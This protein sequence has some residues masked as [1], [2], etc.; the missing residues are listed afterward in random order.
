MRK[1]IVIEW[2]QSFDPKDSTCSKCFHAP[3]EEIEG[4]TTIRTIG[5]VLKREEKIRVVFSHKSSTIKPLEGVRA[6]PELTEE[7]GNLIRLMGRSYLAGMSREYT[8]DHWISTD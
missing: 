2:D 6:L 1:Q 4:T 3:G 7:E 8:I 5:T